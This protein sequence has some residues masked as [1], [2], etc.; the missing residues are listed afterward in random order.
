MAANI[1]PQRHRC[2]KHDWCTVP[3]HG[4]QTHVGEARVLTT[5]RGTEIRVSLTAEGNQEPILQ[6]EAAFESG[7]PMMELAALDPVEAVELAGF[8]LRLARV[9]QDARHEIR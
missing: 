3:G 6:M 4:H 5:S 8:L 9:A 2:P 7:T 1:P